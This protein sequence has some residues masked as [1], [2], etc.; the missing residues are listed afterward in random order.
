MRRG[1]CLAVA[2]AFLALTAPGCGAA[3]T[4]PAAQPA[5]E[6]TTFE[7]GR[8][9][10]LPVYF[11]SDPLGPRSEKQGVVTRSYEA[12]GASPEQVLEFYRNA[13]DYRWRMVTPIERIGV[14]TVRAD[15]EDGQ[16]R[17]RVSAT[18]APALDTSDGGVHAVVTQYSLTLHPI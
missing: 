6:V 15:W 9:D 18:E 5:P 7:Q 4:P 8:F 14:G 3:D 1:P 10:D 16:Y 11:R 12:S 17:L 13:L 2:A